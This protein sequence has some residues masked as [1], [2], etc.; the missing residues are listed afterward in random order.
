MTHLPIHPFTGL[1]A[2]GF[3]RDGRPIYPVRGGSQP[4][5]TPPADPAPTPAPTPAPEPPKQDEPLGPAG[6][7]ALQTERKAREELEK[8]LAGLAPLQKLAEAL[9]ATADPG[10]GKTDVD[11]LRERFDAQQREI[12]EER[13]GRWR[14]EVAQ[15]AGLGPELA[16]R[17]QGDSREALL[18]D[19]QA[20]AALIPAQPDGPRT[21]APD[22][23]QGSRGTPPAPSLDAQ[24]AEAKAAGNFR[25]AIALERSKLQNL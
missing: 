19:A 6:L 2:I 12:A 15:E 10:S 14:A 9:G 18:A 17:L 21:P 11:A 13:T 3:R 25:R 22:P 24:I 16:A 7:K 8:Q 5:V 4:I 20:L 23:S 1:R